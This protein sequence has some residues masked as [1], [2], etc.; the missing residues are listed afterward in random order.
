MSEDNVI[1]LKKPESIINDQIT[2][3]LRQGA[4]K[5]LAQALEA[6]IDHFISQYAG[7]K[8]DHG[9]KRIVRN[10]YLPER[11]IQSGIGSV[12][13]QAPR[14]RDRHL[15]APERIHFSSAILPH[16]FAEPKALRS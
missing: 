2:D 3:I 1:A 11:T 4:R 7:L 8:D 15:H 5:M 6:E 13:V 16:I 10:G 12:P 14:A 9:R